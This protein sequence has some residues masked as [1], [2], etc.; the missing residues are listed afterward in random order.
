MRVEL[1]GRVVTDL[2]VDGVDLKD[3]PDY[4]DAYFC[5]ATWADTG[6]TLTDDELGTLT[7]RY[8]EVVN[9]MANACILDHDYDQ[10]A[11]LD[12]IVYGQL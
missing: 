8:S 9:Q 5:S 1:H 4:C 12:A 11:D 7:D 3:H 6:A 10:Y 2:A